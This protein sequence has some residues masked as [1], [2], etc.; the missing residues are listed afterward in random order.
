MPAK[1]LGFGLMRLPMQE[2]A[3]DLEKTKAM[4]DLFLEK[5]FTYCDG[6]YTYG[7]SYGR[8]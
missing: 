5:G 8:I 4:V 6:N 7:T 2:K 1:Q 3:I